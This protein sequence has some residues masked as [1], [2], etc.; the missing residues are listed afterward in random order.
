MFIY[1]DM[2]IRVFIY[3]DMYTCVFIY[4]DM[5][6]CIYI[7]YMCMCTCVYT[8]IYTPLEG[9]YFKVPNWSLAGLAGA[10]PGCPPVGP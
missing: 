7:L 10:Y 6:M 4:V 3:V 8:H 2:Y 5:C 9:L 1:V